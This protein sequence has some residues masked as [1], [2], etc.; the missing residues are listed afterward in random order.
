[1]R[2][3]VTPRQKPLLTEK[4]LKVGKRALLITSVLV[5]AVLCSG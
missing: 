1:M 3:F 5:V 2:N 4:S